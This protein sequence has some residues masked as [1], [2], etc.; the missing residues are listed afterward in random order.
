[1]KLLR[2]NT[3]ILMT[4]LLWSTAF[5]AGTPCGTTITNVAY[6]DYKD[7]N[8]NSLAQVTS[9]T[10]TTTVSQVAGVDLHPALLSNTIPTQSTHLSSLTL[11]NTGN[12]NDQFTLS[13]NTT[14]TGDASFTV[15]LYHDINGNG[16]IDGL[17]AP[18]AI[19]PEMAADEELDLIYLIT[20]ITNGGAPDGANVASV[21][22]AVSEFDDTVTDTADTDHTVAASVLDVTVT[23][24][25]VS[26]L[27]GETIT[28][29]VCFENTGSATSYDLTFIG[30]IPENTT[31]VPGTLGYY[32]TDEFANANPLTD[33]DDGVEYPPATEGDF[34]V[35]NADL[36]TV[37]WGD[38]APMDEGCVFYQVVVVD[39][40]PA[41]TTIQPEVDVTFE[42]GEG[43]PYPPG[44]YHGDPSIVDQFAGVEAGD[45]DT[46]VADPG[47]EVTYSICFTNTGNGEDVFNISYV[48]NFWSWTFY[49][50]SNGNGNID[51]DDTELTDTNSDGVIDL[52]TLDQDE[53]VCIIG[54]SA[55]PA[56]TNDGTVDVM[57]VTATSVFDDT[58]SDSGTITTTVTAPI[59]S[60]NKSVTPEGEQPP[61]TV[62]TYRVDVLNAGTGQATDVVI[63]DAVPAHT[64]YISGSMTVA[65]VAKTD[66]ADGDSGTFSSNQVEFQIPTMG[67]GGSTYITFQVVIN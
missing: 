48:S 11:T 18:I 19:T 17:D 41:G 6:G 14:I 54:T 39:G 29:S 23:P 27:P 67:P 22:T 28:Y 44:T 7:A 66:A 49:F 59:L 56:G 62:L 2:F 20:D 32:P 37:V 26:P 4:V 46:A 52:G 53:T 36:V 12:C 21:I 35:T 24:S 38:A 64:T 45:D 31:Y 10:V 33:A 65:G 60:L 43:T 47:D 1:M 63:T 13:V 61:G 55:I 42:N 34:N 16:V 30:E 58:V 40:T 57:T 8:G 5:G 9:N 3:G 15:E 50:D 25:D 51:P